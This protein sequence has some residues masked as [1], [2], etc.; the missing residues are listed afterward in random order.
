MGD[1]ERGEGGETEGGCCGQGWRGHRWGARAADAGGQA[2]RRAGKPGMLGIRGRPGYGGGVGMRGAPDMGMMG[3]WGCGDAQH[4]GMLGALGMRGCWRCG[5]AAV[6]ISPSPAPPAAP[7]RLTPRSARGSS[8]APAAP[9]SRRRRRSAPLRSPRRTGSPRAGRLQREG[10]SG[11]TAGSG[12]RPA[13]H[14]PAP[15]DRYGSE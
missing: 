3:M 7:P 6:A 4:A 9:S 8:A 2:P 12:A 13:G 11:G 5:D 14:G 15:A 10:G 1:K